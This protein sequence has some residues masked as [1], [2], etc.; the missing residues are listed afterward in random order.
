MNEVVE[1][2]KIDY[3]SC[4]NCGAEMRKFEGEEDNIA[5]AN[6]TCF[7]CGADIVVPYGKKIN[8]EVP[9]D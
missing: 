3:V 9:I 7:G 1:G 8:M 5:G 6:Y 4:P 2:K